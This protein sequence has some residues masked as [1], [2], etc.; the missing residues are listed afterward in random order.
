MNVPMCQGVVPALFEKFRKAYNHSV[1]QTTRGSIKDCGYDVIA[2]CEA[3][4]DG[5]SSVSGR[6]IFGGEHSYAKWV[7]INQKQYRVAAWRTLMEFEGFQAMHAMYLEDSSRQNKVMAA[8]HCDNTL[9][10]EYK[11]IANL[12]L[13]KSAI[14]MATGET[15]RIF[16][17]VPYV[18]T[19]AGFEYRR[20]T[21]LA[22]VSEL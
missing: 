3:G 15:V 17:D 12:K 8:L 4:K 6:N 21:E 18:Y 19:I 1:D 14:A 5:W 9:H 2:T 22:E 16:V 7:S 13:L 11:D 20:S 10:G